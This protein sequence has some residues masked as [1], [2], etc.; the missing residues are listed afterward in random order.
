MSDID[1]QIATIKSQLASAQLASAR[2]EVAL[3]TAQ[4]N[5]EQAMQ[6]LRQT[7][8]VDSPEQVRA[9]LVGLQNDLQEK[10]AEVSK[11]LSQI[12]L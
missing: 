9:K 4:L 8:G 5:Y 12:N 7:Y 11:I 3:E 10:M 2:A 6:T 1:T